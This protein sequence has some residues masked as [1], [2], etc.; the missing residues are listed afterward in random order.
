MSRTTNLPVRTAIALAFLLTALA[1]GPQVFALP[2]ATTFSLAAS[3][4]M[5][6]HDAGQ[7]YADPVGSIAPSAVPL[8][9]LR[10]QAAGLTPR[11]E[12]GG[13]VYALDGT[14]HV[15]AM[16]AASGTLVYKYLTS[17]VKSVAYKAPL[18]Y[19][20]RGSEIRLV[21]ASSAAL[22]GTAAAPSSNH[23]IPS[24]ASIVLSGSYIYT[25]IGATGPGTLARFFA[26]DAATGSLVWQ[27]SGSMTSVPCIAGSTLYMSYGPFGS[28]DSYLIDPATGVQ[29]TVIRGLGALQWNSAGTMLYA[30]VLSGSGSNLQASTRA[31]DQDGHLKYVAHDMLFGAALPDELLG[32]LPGAVDARS[33]TTGRRLWETQV[34]GLASVAL[35][36]LDS[37]QVAVSGNLVI[38]QADDGEV[39][40]LDRTTGQL[41]DTLQPPFS[42]TA[43]KNLI[44]GG[45]IIFESISPT[46]KTGKAGPPTLLAFG[47]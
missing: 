9:H 8:L 6:G 46:L 42:G 14:G 45:G 26:F 7:S 25:G 41:L 47:P 43:A 34:P 20:N 40:L 21:V 16:N 31:Y 18:L 44:V 33:A 5:L 39:V 24:F 1:P 38:V 27:D 35:G 12:A 13:V 3:W 10:W 19:L 4:P 36:S 37:H 17:G 29:R 32:L 30:S 22:A 23:Q 11:I 28:A 15:L 2:A